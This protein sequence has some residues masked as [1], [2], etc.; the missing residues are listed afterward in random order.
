MLDKKDLLEFMQTKDIVVRDTSHFNRGVI[1]SLD[2]LIE[3]KIGLN[4]RLEGLNQISYGLFKL[5]KALRYIGYLLD[6]RR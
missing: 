1:S 2:S 4:K 6:I 5:G 3:H